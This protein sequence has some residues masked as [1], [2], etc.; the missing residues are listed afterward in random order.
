MT[1]GYCVYEIVQFIAAKCHLKSNDIEMLQILLRLNF[2]L[3]KLLG[4]CQQKMLAKNVINRAEPLANYSSMSKIFFFCV[5]DGR[6]A[7]HITCRERALYQLSYSCLYPNKCL[8]TNLPHDSSYAVMFY[9]F[10]FVND[11]YVG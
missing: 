10:S 2:N 1:F 11:V 9:I 4:T 5:V 8:N 3:S 6:F 7:D